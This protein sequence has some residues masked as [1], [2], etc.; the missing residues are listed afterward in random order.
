MAPCDIHDVSPPFKFRILQP[1]KRYFFLDKWFVPW[2][3]LR[4]KC[5]RNFVRCYTN[6]FSSRNCRNIKALYLR[7]DFAVG[8]VWFIDLGQINKESQSASIFCEYS[9]IISQWHIISRELLE[10]SHEVPTVSSLRQA[11]QCQ[12]FP[13]QNFVCRF[14]IRHSTLCNFL[15]FTTLKILRNLYKFAKFLVM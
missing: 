4:T 3:K 8:L 7:L 6:Y 13:H 9:L 11:E 5:F 12:G 10:A 1:L 14:D 15:E 2:N